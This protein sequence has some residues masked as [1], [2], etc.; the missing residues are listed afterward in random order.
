MAEPSSPTKRAGQDTSR[1]S[2]MPRH[3]GIMDQTMLDDRAAAAKT[4]AAAVAKTAARSD[5]KA[6]Q[7]CV[8]SAVRIRDMDFS[9]PD[10]EALAG[11]RLLP[12]AH[13]PLPDCSTTARL[14]THH[15][16]PTAYPPPRLVPAALGTPFSPEDSDLVR[17]GDEGELIGFQPASAP[18][19]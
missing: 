15:H 19:K 17:N 6:V 7:P 14:L 13:S 8:G 5:K 9:Y 11:K 4:I 10:A 1:A 2:K 3:T 16:C 18:R 12:V